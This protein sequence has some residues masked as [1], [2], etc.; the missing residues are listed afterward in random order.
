MAGWQGTLIRSTLL[1]DDRLAALP[2]GMRRAAEPVFKEQIYF[3]KRKEK[4]KNPAVSFHFFFFPLRAGR[5][6][7]SQ[8]Q[9]RHSIDQVR[10]VWARLTGDS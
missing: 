5:R 6:G 4:R 1:A 7:Q 8:P 3:K 10:A 9:T 2:V